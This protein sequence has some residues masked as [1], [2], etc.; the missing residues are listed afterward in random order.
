MVLGWCRYFLSTSEY[1]G[2][3]LQKCFWLDPSTGDADMLGSSW[4]AN[5][6]EHHFL[7]EKPILS[8]IKVVGWILGIFIGK[9]VSVIWAQN[10]GK[11]PEDISLNHPLNQPNFVDVV[12]RPK[13]DV[14]AVG[15]ILY[16][17]WTAKVYRPR[18]FWDP[19]DGLK[20]TAWW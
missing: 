11:Q 6:W 2:T 13:V 17:T 18:F 15:C 12:D 16:E 3:E 8:L 1:P 20:S 19:V 10:L 7:N 9:R 14:W 4:T 5:H